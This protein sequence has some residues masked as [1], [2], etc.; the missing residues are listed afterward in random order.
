MA[1]EVLTEVV[2]QVAPERESEVASAFTALLDKGLPHGLLRTEL[3]SGPT[4]VWRIQSLWRDQAALDAMRALPEP[5]AALALFRGLG[6]EPT[7]TILSVHE[8]RT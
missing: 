3:L 8:S 6:A 2:A 7:L 1:G 4:G 5:P